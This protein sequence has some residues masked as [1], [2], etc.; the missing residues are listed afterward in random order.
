MNIFVLL[1]ALP[2]LSFIQDEVDVQT[3]EDRVT[4][5]YSFEFTTSADPEQMFQVLKEYSS[6]SS[7][8]VQSALSEVEIIHRSDR[9]WEVRHLYEV[10]FAVFSD[11]TEMVL[12]YEVL[13]GDAPMRLEWGLVESLDGKV[14]DSSGFW[15]VYAGEDG[16]G[17]R[18]KYVSRMV[19]EKKA[20]VPFALNNFSKG[21]VRRTLRGLAEAA[22]EAESGAGEEAGSGT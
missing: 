7:D 3:G 12:A 22:A 1:L 18:V 8:T 15:E 9:G 10:G 13:E 2:A 21:S 5:V 19:Y 14:F 17:S 6:E 20:G 11:R 16:S 4:A